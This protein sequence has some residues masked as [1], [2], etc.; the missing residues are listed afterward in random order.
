MNIFFDVQNLYYLPQYTP[1]I[2]EFLSRGHA[3]N[4][5][6]Y[7]T[8]N[9]TLST[10]LLQL[11]ESCSITEIK[12]AQ[13]ALQLYLNKTPDWIIFG[14]EFQQ[15]ELI[16]QHSRTAQMGHG[17]GPKPSYYHKSS[18]PMTVRFIEGSERLQKIQILYPDDLF[19]QVGYSKLDPIFNGEEPGFNL[20]L[21]GLSETKKTLLYAPTF[22]P[23][24]IECFDDHWPDQFKDFNIIIKPHSLTLARKQYAPQRQKLNHWS[25]FPN[26][27]VASESSLSLIPYLVTADLLISEASSSLFE[28]IALDKPVIICDFFKL[29]WSYRGIFSYRFNKRFAKDNV[30]YKDIGTHISNA[31]ELKS[32]VEVQLSHPQQYQQARKSATENHVGPTDGKTSERIVTLI[33]QWDKKVNWDQTSSSPNIS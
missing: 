3:C 5:I 22:N 25:K 23:S 12:D 13:E 30:V 31:S 10:R 6:I 27:H 24:S 29:K 20:T 2:K 8:K 32:A 18:T 19:I 21:A 28:F 26:V 1:V 15:L 14:N 4:C 17:I 11:P 16:H 33:E 9:T 7:T